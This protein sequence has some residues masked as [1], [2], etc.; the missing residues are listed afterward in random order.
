MTTKIT[1]SKS[2]SWDFDP[3]KRQ[4][5]LLKAW[6]RF[7]ATGKISLKIVPDHIA[8]SWCSSRENNVDPYC[9]S[10]KS[11]L[12]PEEYRKQLNRSQRII[13]LASPIIKNLFESFGA[14]RYIVSLYDSKG[15]H[16]MRL[17]QPQDLELREQ[18]GLVVGLCF[19][20]ISVGTAGFNLACRLRRPVRMIG[21]EHYMEPL[22]HV[23][24]VYAPILEPRSQ[25]VVGVIAVGGTVLVEY[26]QAESIVVAAST[27]IENLLELDQAKTETV[28]YS[29]SLQ[30]TIDSLEDGIVVLDHLGNIREMNLVARQIL[31][32]EQEVVEKIKITELSNADPLGEIVAKMLQFKNRESYQTEIQI[33]DNSYL[34]KAKSIREENET[35]HGVLVQLK[36]I[37]DLSQMLHDI[38]ADQPRYTLDSIVGSSNFILEIK[39]LASIA[40]KT[41]AP[42]IIEGESGTGK[43]LV[44]QA[45]HNASNRKWKPFVAINCAAI[46]AEL[47]E[48]TIFGHKKGAFTGAIRTHIGKFELAHEGTLFLD[49]IAD[50]PMTM[51]AKMLRTIEEGRIERVGGEKSITVNARI[52]SASNKNLLEQI[53]Q[54][55]FRQD[56]FFRLNVFKIA[57]PALR[58]RKED[59]AD[60]TRQFVT[61]FELIFEKRV[62]KISPVYIQRLL[63]YEWPGNVREL[64]NAIQY[65]MARLSGQTLMPQHLDGYFSDM[66]ENHPLIAQKNID[67]FA[68]SKL[69]KKTIRDALQR[70]GGNKTKTAKALGIG[71]ATLYRKLKNG[72][73]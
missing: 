65:S 39:N 57:I 50:M 24:G 47:I 49:E 55:Q 52:V 4:P 21:C 26:P 15:Y 17:A 45:I 61:E 7:I 13:S 5:E 14:S 54:N 16:L 46:P 62:S 59:I 35:T 31:K 30:I 67:N 27:A 71:R 68:L 22:H 8:E 23:S 44:A 29:R 9:F 60:L 41:D 38:T 34:V 70:H 33:G 43:E 19:D 40:A 32:L 42:V 53:G 1:E 64:R 51:Q 72:K 73:S 20:E 25:S 69:E 18:H 48:S 12:N 36:N 58:E 56:L 2:Y 63:D 3:S 37:R 66:T 11:L 28:I 6:K 10:P